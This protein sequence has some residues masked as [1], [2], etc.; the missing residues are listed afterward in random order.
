MP[1]ELH[2]KLYKNIVITGG[3]SS[4]K[5][6]GDKILDAMKKKDEVELFGPKNR[7]YACF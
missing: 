1:L 3:S 7:Q 5:G 6:L 4:I 2:K